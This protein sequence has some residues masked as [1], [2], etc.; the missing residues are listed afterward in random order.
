MNEKILLEAITYIPEAMIL[1]SE[2]NVTMKTALCSYRRRVRTLLLVAL[3]VTLAFLALT[4]FVIYRFFY[5]TPIENTNLYV[6]V[7]DMALSNTVPTIEDPKVAA[8]VLAEM[9]LEDMMTASDERT[10]TITKYKNLNVHLYPTIDMDEDAA[11]IYLLQPSEVSKNTWIVEIDVLFQYQ[12]T[13]SPIGS[14]EGQWI[15]VLYQ[16]SPVGFLLTKDGT[17]YTLQ[18]RYYTANGN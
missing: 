13:L 15:D 5:S 17:E 14:I 12:G 18:S 7:D 6:Y 16:A 9:Y 11:A 8:T 4:G 1:E 3:F 10:F 2:N